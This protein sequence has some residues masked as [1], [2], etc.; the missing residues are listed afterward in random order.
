MDKDSSHHCSILRVW[1][2]MRGWER[3][4]PWAPCRELL[5]NAAAPGHLLPQLSPYSVAFLW[6]VSSGRKLADTRLPVPSTRAYNTEKT[7]TCSWDTAVV[8]W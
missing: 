4:P 3:A 7:Q 2:E 5:S 6:G 1:R 8:G